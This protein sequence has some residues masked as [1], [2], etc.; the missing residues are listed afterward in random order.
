MRYT[1]LAMGLAI[2]IAATFSLAPA[3]A[4]L[5]GP[6]KNAQ[7]QCKHFNAYNPNHE[8]FYW[9]D[10]PKD[11]ASVRPVMRHHHRG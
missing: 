5:G 11:A 6:I 1:A 8:F 3:Q 10:C 2:A 7:G 4:E 9:G